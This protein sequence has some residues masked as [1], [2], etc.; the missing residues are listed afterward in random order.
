MSKSERSSDGGNR[1]H[2]VSLPIIVKK[3]KVGQIP[4]YSCISLLVVPSLLYWI[5]VS[6]SLNVLLYFGAEM[7]TF[8]IKH[9]ENR[10]LFFNIVPPR[11]PTNPFAGKRVIIFYITYVN[12]VLGPGGEQ[13][14]TAINVARKP[15]PKYVTWYNFI[16]RK[17]NSKN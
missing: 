12:G 5:Q 16:I 9:I 6:V 15:E 1:S 3:K 13:Y 8:C 2:N 4:Q 7:A 10:K 14:H 11:A 17:Q